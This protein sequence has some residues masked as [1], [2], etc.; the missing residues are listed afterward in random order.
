MSNSIIQINNVNKWFG[1]FQ[2]LKDI[3][4]QDLENLHS[5]DV[6]TDWKNIK[7]EI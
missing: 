1:D 4:L 7:K 6:L 2:V 5:S 3:N